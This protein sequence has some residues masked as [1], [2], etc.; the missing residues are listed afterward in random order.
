MHHSHGTISTFDEV[1]KKMHEALE[2]FTGVTIEE[3]S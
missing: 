3:A 1:R 2:K